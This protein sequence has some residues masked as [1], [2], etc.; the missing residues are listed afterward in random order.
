MVP[1]MLSNGNELIARLVKRLE[2]ALPHPPTIQALA[3]E[4]AMSPRTLSR[5]VR[6]AT[7][8]STMSLMQSV[9]LNRARL[10]IESSRLTIEGVA[11]QVG[12][13]DATALRRLMHKSA[14]ANPSRFRPSVL[15][16]RVR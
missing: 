15:G 10:L 13:K 14:G 7:G 3:S 6:E 9:R 5:H 2:A 1:K 8:Q 4:F 12:Y 16:P 11:E